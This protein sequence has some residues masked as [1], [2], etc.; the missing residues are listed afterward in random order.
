MTEAAAS[1]SSS[2]DIDRLVIYAARYA[3]H[4]SD[5]RTD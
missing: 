4:A 1:T 5:A 3:C 2:G